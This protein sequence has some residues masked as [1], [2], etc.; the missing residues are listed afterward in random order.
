MQLYDYFKHKRDLHIVSCTTKYHDNKHKGNRKG[1]TGFGVSDN[2]SDAII[3]IHFG[4]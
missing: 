4:I 2:I 3:L 1:N